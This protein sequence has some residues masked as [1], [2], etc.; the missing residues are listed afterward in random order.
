MRIVKIRKNTS[1]KA[2]ILKEQSG[3]VAILVAICL[4][5]FIGF[6]AFAIDIG[7]LYLARNELQNAADAGALAGARFLYNDYGTSVNTN[8]NGI[9]SEAATAN[10]S[11]NV[12]V[13]VNWTGGNTGD[14][15]RGH[16]SF[17]AGTLERDFYPSDNENPT[18][19]W[20]VSEEELDQNPDFINAVRVVARRE[21]TPITK[22]FAQIFLLLG[23]D[24]AQLDDLFKLSA[25]AVAYIGYSGELLEDEVEQ[26]IAICE[27]AL[28]C[29]DPDTGQTLPGYCCDIGR[30]FSDGQ[31]SSNIETASWT[32]F[33]QE[34]ENYDCGGM[35]AADSNTLRDLVSDAA[36][37]E[38]EDGKNPGVDFNL[39]IRVTN[40]TNTTVLMRLINC[41]KQVTNIER[42]WQMKL[43]V[44]DCDVSSPTCGKL[45]G[46]VVVNVIWVNDQ[47]HNDPVYFTKDGKKTG[48]IMDFMEGVGQFSDWDH[49]KTP[50]ATGEAAW[51]SFRDHF[52]LRNAE[53]DPADFQ[54]KTIYFLPDCEPHPLSGVAGGNNYGVLAK[55]PV[56]VK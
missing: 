41:W 6:A 16:W 10:K 48:E 24:Q 27:E 21:A 39:P 43:P 40:G 33:Y 36:L 52:D 7:H 50:F 29:I 18:V 17:G 47:G 35:G 49:T 54:E 55:V 2:L 30:M 44:I 37:T 32:D 5:V 13:E 11:E 31:G 12:S 45:A 25:E 14:V 51:I 8:A 3:A 4:I 53:N 56:L 26:P 19:L 42:P 1:R 22:F 34:E 46:A 28:E 20:G 9:A 38:C 15:Q 23:M